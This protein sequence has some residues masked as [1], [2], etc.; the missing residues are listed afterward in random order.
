MERP[1]KVSRRDPK[2]NRTWRA[3]GRHC[4]KTARNGASGDEAICGTQATDVG[5]PHRDYSAIWNTI[6]TLVDRQK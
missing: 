4:V 5:A 6:L 3:G 2:I 1:P